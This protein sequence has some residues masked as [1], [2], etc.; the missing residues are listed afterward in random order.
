VDGGKPQVPSPFGLARLWRERVRVRAKRN[1]GCDI[2][3]AGGVLLSLK[4]EL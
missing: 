2:E 1:L 4:A 3:S